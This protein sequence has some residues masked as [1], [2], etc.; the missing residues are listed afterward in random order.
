MSDIAWTDVTSLPNAPPAFA[1]VSM[2]AQTAILAFANNYLDVDQFDGESGPT[3][4]LARCYLAAHFA[5]IGP[6]AGILTGT[7]EDDLSDTYALIPVP[8][9]RDS[10][11][12]FWFRS[13]FGA[14]FWMLVQSSGARMPIVT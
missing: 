11:M 5:T 13:G 12:A 14:A 8:I 6:L 3:T 9:A 2:V 1:T 10:A 4:H 7:K